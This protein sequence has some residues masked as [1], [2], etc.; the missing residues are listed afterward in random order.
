MTAPSPSL[1]PKPPP[2]AE[3]DAKAAE[4]YKTFS[5]DPELAEFLRKLDALRVILQGRTTVVFDT[6]V[7]PFDLLNAAKKQPVLNSAK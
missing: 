3:G 6:N 2:S 1:K 5:Q 4:S 7:P